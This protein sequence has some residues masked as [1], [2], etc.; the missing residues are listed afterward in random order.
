MPEKIIVH[1]KALGHLTRG[2]YRSPASALRELVSN[3]WDANATCVRIET[4][5]P[6][7]Q[8]IS[9]VDNGDGFSKA[10]FVRLMGGFGNSDKRARAQKLKFG[11]PTIGRL[12]IGLLGIAQIC[13][14]F[15][16]RSRP[17]KGEGFVARIDLYDALRRRIDS[18]DPPVIRKPTVGAKGRR[19]VGQEVVVGQ[20]EFVNDE[21]WQDQEF[22]TTIESEDLIPTFAFAFRKTYNDVT[23]AHSSA[24]GGAPARERKRGPIPATWP[25]FLERATSSATVQELG[26]YWRWLWDLAALCPVRYV[27]PDALP[28]KAIAEQDRRIGRFN[29]RVI[30]DGV[31]I[32]KPVF[33]DSEN[34]GGYTRLI[35]PRTMQKVM[36]RAL[37]YSGY[38]F[39]QEG[40][41]LRPAELRGVMVRI[42]DVGVGLYDPSFLDY[43]INEGPRSRWVT[44]E[45]FVEEG[46]EDALNVDRDSFNRYAP[47][48]QALQRAFHQHLQK[49]VFPKVYQQIEV[50]TRAAQ[51]DRDRA[52]VASLTKVL[53]TA[54]GK[55][56]VDIST[57][58][59]LAKQGAPEGATVTVTSEAIRIILAKDGL[60]G[61]AKPLRSL[62]AMVLAIYDVA[63]RENG[64][65]AQ[66]ARFSTLLRDLLKTR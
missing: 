46:L 40:K 14:G 18:E 2:L 53:S 11:R 31:E 63:Q 33:V 41:Q 59:G 64:A 30:V 3:A 28:K 16:I 43:R 36:S 26:D 60:T 56:A 8:R 48:F 22:G 19:R 17:R 15:V 65:V 32:R 45:L 1:E 12:G 61:A 34:P 7:F 51:L 27:T 23:V 20:Y 4:D 62:G 37:T 9:V 66:R 6:S 24:K 25:A 49:E 42:A 29:F 58:R 50:R 38:L 54:Y 35:I 57:S 13:G 39:V 47:E 52:R 44:G 10:D 5:R 55:R 21:D